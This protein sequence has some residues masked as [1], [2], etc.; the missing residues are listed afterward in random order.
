MGSVTS[1][2]VVDSAGDETR[3]RVYPLWFIAP[4]FCWVKPYKSDQWMAKSPNGISTKNNI[5]VTTLP[6]WSQW[7]G[8]RGDGRGEERDKHWPLACICRH[9]WDRV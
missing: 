6:V 5:M 3:H 1:H 8:R 2:H 9:G 7:L 4:H